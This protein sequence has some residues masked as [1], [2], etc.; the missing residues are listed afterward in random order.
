MDRKTLRSLTLRPLK[1]MGLAFRQGGLALRRRAPF[2]VLK[3]IS[4][5]LHRGETLGVIG[6]NAAGKSTLLRVL[7]GI[8]RHDRGQFINRAQSISLLTLQT[9]F[10]PYLTGRQNAVLSGI[11]L[12][13]RRAEVE[14]RMEAII[15]FSELGTFIDQPLSAYSSGMRARLGFAVAYQVQ[16]DI[17][18]IDE[19]LGVGDAEFKEKSTQA[20][21][22]RIRSDKTIVLVSHVP[23]MIRELCDRAIW[24]EE[25]VTRAVGNVD[26][27]T[28]AY[29]EEVSRRQQRHEHAIRAL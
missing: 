17:L 11:L 20:M 3:D 27:V 8:I 9:G 29:H 14:A 4:F 10:V 18:L 28:Q 23:G 16:P 7:A 26:E 19:T 2:W 25:G 15:D 5:D 21:R 6:R 24:I 22:E 12:G 1:H 13:L